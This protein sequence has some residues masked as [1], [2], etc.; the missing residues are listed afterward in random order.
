MA[1]RYSQELFLMGTSL[2]GMQARVPE[3]LHRTNNELERHSLRLLAIRLFESAAACDPDRCHV[4][5]L[6]KPVPCPN[7]PCPVVACLD[8]MGEAHARPG[9][10]VDEP[11]RRCPVAVARELE[12]RFVDGPEEP[13]IAF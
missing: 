11:E 3:M 12:P 1:T 6:G 5:G 13:D 10:K 7:A 2:R 9:D 8:C 4:C